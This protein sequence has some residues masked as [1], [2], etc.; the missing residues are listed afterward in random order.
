MRGRN[1][2]RTIKDRFK[3][4]R[5]RRIESR[6]KY[7][8]E[9]DDAYE[10]EILYDMLDSFESQFGLR[11]TNVE[12]EFDFK[13]NNRWVLKGVIKDLIPNKWKM[14]IDGGVLLEYSEYPPD[15]ELGYVYINPIINGI[16]VNA[17]V[18]GIGAS[19]WT[20]YDYETDRWG[21]LVWQ[22]W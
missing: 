19:I 18:G 7:L 14:P 15:D 1:R 17:V 8:R 13:G 9:Q 10:L 6:R 12:E 16:D 3:K 2:R 21:E 22:N 20:T 4:P 5:K 11:V